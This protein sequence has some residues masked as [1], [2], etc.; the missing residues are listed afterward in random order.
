MT[1]GVAYPFVVYAALPHVTAKVLL[2]PLF[3]LLALRILGTADVGGRGAFLAMLAAGV[4]LIVLALVDPNLALKAYPVAMSLAAAAAFGFSLLGGPSL[5]ERIAR[6]RTPGLPPSGVR[7]TRRV[8]I[9]WCCF[10]IANAGASASISVF[11]T[12]E[13]WMLWNG[14]LF[15]LLAGALL[16]GEWLLRQVIWGRAA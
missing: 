13:Q 9:V 14:M 15:Y 10:L 16:G 8:T 2:V 6:R 4:L 12:L 11:G 3:A 5:I 7:Y 1:A